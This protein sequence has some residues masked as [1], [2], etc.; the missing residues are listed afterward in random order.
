MSNK[1]LKAVIPAAGLGTRMLP[2][3]KEMPKEMLP[4]FS[5]DSGQVCLKPLLQIV[6]E[7]LFDSGFTEFCF[8]VGRGKRSIEDHFT[9]DYSYIDY[10]RKNNKQ[11]VADVLENFYN[12]IERSYIVWINQPNPKGFGHAVMVS[13]TF[14]GNNDF[15]VHAGDTQIISSGNKEQ[16]GR[17]TDVHSKYGADATILTRR[18]ENPAGHGIIIPEE[19]DHRV[20]LV[21][22]AVEKPRNPPTNF[23]IMPL[24]VFNHDLFRSLKST[25]AGYGGEIQLTD[26][27]RGLISSGK[28]VISVEMDPADLRLDVGS[29][30]YYFEALNISYNRA[31]SS[32][33]EELTRVKT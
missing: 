9:P 5:A 1:K 26:G 21:K 6:F 11:P 13:E 7:Q 4:L 20:Y 18:L 24:Y 28:K 10:L 29:P 2:I 32:I 15:L 3:T 23:G 30:D 19:I 17:L 12:R 22:D 27:I 31:M 8:V 14:V 16:I 33:K 25:T